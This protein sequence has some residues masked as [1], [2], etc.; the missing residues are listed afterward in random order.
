MGVERMTNLA[1]RAEG[2]SKCYRIDQARSFG[3]L[4]AQFDLYRRRFKARLR[5]QDLAE[6]TIW[7]LKDVSFSLQKGRVLG[8]IG[9]RT[10]RR[11]N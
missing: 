3:S 8:V 10:S 5:G 9:L 6:E 7:S 2:L 4:A 1:I 11:R